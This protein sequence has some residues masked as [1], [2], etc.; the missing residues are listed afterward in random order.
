M[1]T[2]YKINLKEPI[3]SDSLVTFFKA[4]F[5]SMKKSG[6]LAGW[7]NEAFAFPYNLEVAKDKILLKGN[8]ERYE[9]LLILINDTDILI[10]LTPLSTNGDKNKAIQYSK[11]LAKHFKT[12]LVL[13]NNR[14]MNYA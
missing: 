8:V 7:E 14:T 12:E 11:V 9:Q 13:P 3:T 2:S 6:E 1:E 4:Y 5:E 10:K